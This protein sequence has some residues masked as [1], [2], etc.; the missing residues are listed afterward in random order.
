[1]RCA[2]QDVHIKRI[3]CQPPIHNFHST[4][5]NSKMASIVDNFCMNK[6]MMNNNDSEV[7]ASKSSRYWQRWWGESWAPEYVAKYFIYFNYFQKKKKIFPKVVMPRPDAAMANAIQEVKDDN[8][9]DVPIRTYKGFW[10][11]ARLL[12]RIRIKKAPWK[13]H[14]FQICLFPKVVMPRP[15][16]AMANAIQEVKDDNRWDVPIRTY[17]LKE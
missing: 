5:T 7:G 13:K 8:R 6:T 2:H 14:L 10:Q 11:C 4:S 1:M 17:T 9:W 16:A 12:M 3:T 15:D